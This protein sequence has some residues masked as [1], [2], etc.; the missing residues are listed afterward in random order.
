MSYRHF[1]GAAVAAACF[2]LPSRHGAAK[3]GVEGIGRAPARLPDGR[4]HRAH[5]QEARGADRRPLLDPDVSVDAAWRRE[6]MIEQA[7]VG[8][9]QIARISVAHGRG[10]RSERV[11][12][13]RSSFAMSST[14]ESDRRPIGQELLERTSNAPTSRL[15][16]LAGW[17]PA[18][19]MSTRT[20]RHQARRPQGHED[21]HDG[22]PAVRRDHERDGRQRR[23][24][25]FNELYS[26]LQTGVVDG[27]ENNPPTLLAQ[28]HYQVSK[29]TASRAT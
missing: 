17:T 2:A 25:G 27:A 6:E 1:I 28:N 11:L 12:T 21:P 7:Q 5:G 15:I 26:A 24:D 29:F 22:Q 23:G 10:G 20:S 18:R 14:C 9:L 16:V 13:C 8:A 4:G 3:T 19:A